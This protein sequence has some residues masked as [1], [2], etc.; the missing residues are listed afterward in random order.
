MGTRRG[1]LN[2]I[3]AALALGAGV[4]TAALAEAP[5]VTPAPQQAPEAATTPGPDMADLL[6]QL[7]SEDPSV[8]RKARSDLLRAWSKSG[9]AAMDLLLKRGQDALAAGD[10]EIAI[11]HLTALIDHAPDFAE[12]YNVRAEA[13]YETGLF[14]PALADIGK[15]LQLNPNQFGAL[16][17]LGLILEQSGFKTKALE[18][19]KASAA[20]DP[21]QPDVNKSIAR[22]EKA[23]MGEEL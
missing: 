16:A 18:A 23:A 1:Y 5:A 13:Y 22:L 21:H 11:E 4:T 9:S 20:I 14:G 17:G 8:W 7:K 19:Y 2:T 12:A 15:A 6:Q 3:V 10:P